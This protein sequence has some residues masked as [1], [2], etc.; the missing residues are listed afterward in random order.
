[1]TWFRMTFGYSVDFHLV[2]N[3]IY[4]CIITVEDRLCSLLVRD[5]DYRSRGSGSIPGATR[6]SEK[7]VT[8]SAQPR[9]YSWRATWKKK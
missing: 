3:L 1:M 4:I 5:P 2:L 9:E 7:S 6:F 8:G